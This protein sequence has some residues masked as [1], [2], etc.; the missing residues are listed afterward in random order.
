[1]HPRW[2]FIEQKDGS[3]AAWRWR[4][5][6]IDGMV[7]T[8]SGSY[9]GFGEVIYAAIKAGFAPQREPWVVI[10]RR[11]ETRFSPPSEGSNRR[12]RPSDLR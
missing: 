6:L 2:F 4:R 11:G 8:T 9:D 3:S 12:I 7:D 5:M 1:M 10:S